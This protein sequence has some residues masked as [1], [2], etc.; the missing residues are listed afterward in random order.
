MKISNNETIIMNK[1]KNLLKFSCLF[2]INMKL[3][4]I[5]NICKRKQLIIIISIKML[6]IQ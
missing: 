6:Y 4:I 3:N 2:K 5:S 1:Y